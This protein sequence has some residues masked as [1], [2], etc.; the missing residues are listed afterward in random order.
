[1]LKAITTSTLEATSIAMLY[2]YC[3]GG[4]NTICTNAPRPSLD[5][6]IAG[7]R[8]GLGHQQPGGGP[9]TGPAPDTPPAQNT[10]IA[11]PKQGEESTTKTHLAPREIRSAGICLGR[12]CLH[13]SNGT[14]QCGHRLSSTRAVDLRRTAGNSGITWQWFLLGCSSNFQAGASAS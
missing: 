1:M 8:P 2:C 12:V 7:T 3:L 5:S 9:P 10:T 13:Q 6:A 11:R 4:A 14:T